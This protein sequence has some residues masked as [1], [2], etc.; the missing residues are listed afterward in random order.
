MGKTTLL[1]TDLQRTVV[2]S[3]DALPRRY[4]P[5]GGFRP[6][7][8][9]WLGF[10]DAHLDHASGCYLLGNGHRA[11]SPALMRFGSPDRLSPF[12]RGGLNAY[13]YCLGDPINHRDPTGQEA[14]DY[15]FPILSILS[16]LAGAFTSGL[17]LRSMSRTRQMHQATGSYPAS[18][19][20]FMTYGTVESHT[21]PPSS[22]DWAFTGIS[23]VSA[24]AGITLG[25]S[26]TVE[27]GEDWQTWALATLTV[28]S[29][30]TSVKE[31][32]ALAQARSWERY[33]VT[34][35]R[36][37]SNGADSAGSTPPAAR[38]NSTAANAIRQSWSELEP[39]A[40]ATGR[41]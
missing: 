40:G 8:G 15:L 14:A 20:G 4:T 33:P 2:R 6:D 3:G 25:I 28:I 36:M 16:N 35:V 37:N 18:R 9:S 19:G 5:Y 12:A 39:V 23:G 31:V 30:G 22:V 21:L 41:R 29:L 34:T 17:R 11:F 10:S 24:V 13:A 38:S 1:A 26:R 32:W 27:P 7:D